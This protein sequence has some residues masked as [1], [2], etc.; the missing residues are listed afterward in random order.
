MKGRDARVKS[1]ELAKEAEKVLSEPL[2][3]PQ[4]LNY[5]KIFDPF[6]LFSKKRYIGMKYEEDPD[7]CKQ[8][9]MGVVLKRRD[10]APIVKEIYQAVVDTIMKDRDLSKSV[11]VA[12]EILRRLVDGK[13]SLK[14]L[15]ITKSLRAEYAN[16]DQIAHKV[17]AERIGDRDPG[18]KPKAND[19]IAFIYFDSTK[20]RETKKQGDRIETPE[21]M[22]AHNLRPDYTH[23]ITNQI[24]KPLTQLF[25]L[26]WS[27]VAESSP[28]VK[29]SRLRMLKAQARQDP[30]NTPEKIETMLERAIDG[31]I[32]K[33]IFTPSVRASIGG[34]VGPMDAFLKG[35]KVTPRKS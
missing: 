24:Q 13:V 35:M 4:T 20:T 16:P 28:S 10:N 15:T 31:D 19:R 26:F 3:A 32:E 30:R 17:L 27:Q 23:Y 14:K 8:A 33:I 18:N 25:R 7:K 21:Y 9:N 2:R 1:L 34:R 5:E 22:V 12:S 6:M 11:S 29:E